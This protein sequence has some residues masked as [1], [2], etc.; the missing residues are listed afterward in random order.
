[1]MCLSCG[2]GDPNAT[3][4]DSRNITYDMLKDAAEAA[5]ITPEEAAKNIAEGTP[6]SD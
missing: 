3:G 2:C 1:M 6:S 4:G 5:G